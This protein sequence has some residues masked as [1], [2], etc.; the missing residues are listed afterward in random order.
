MS[1]FRCN[2]DFHS[3]CCKAVVR[4]WEMSLTQKHGVANFDTQPIRYSVSSSFQKKKK[5]RSICSFTFMHKGHISPLLSDTLVLY[6][7]LADFDGAL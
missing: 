6:V 3:L 4:D 5:K 2:G 7:G 1:G